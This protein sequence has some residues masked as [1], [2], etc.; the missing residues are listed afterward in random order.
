MTTPQTLIGSSPTT[1]SSGTTFDGSM[2][3]SI[4]GQ[5]YT[6]TGTL[7]SIGI[8]VEYHQ[9]F[10]QALNL[11]SVTTIAQHIADALGFSDM[12]GH[13]TDAVGELA[14]LPVIGSEIANLLT[15]ASARITDLEINTSTKTYGVGLA[16]DFTQSPP[17]LPGF[18]IQL[19]A[20]GF[21]VTRSSQGQTTTTTTNPPATS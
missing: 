13:I 14:K 15:S 11:G 21:K 9:N 1:D 17:T 10:D 3:V 6:L 5:T 20:L 7:G 12:G 18:G 16:L 19:F 2:V 4:L 8:V